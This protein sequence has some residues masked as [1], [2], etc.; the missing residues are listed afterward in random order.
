MR[1]QVGKLTMSL[2]FYDC[3]QRIV[4]GSLENM[5]LELSNI[6]IIRN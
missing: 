1:Q 2:S 4:G 6:F 5:N 3:R